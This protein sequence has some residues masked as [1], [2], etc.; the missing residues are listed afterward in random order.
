MIDSIDS[1]IQHLSDEDMPIFSDT[2]TDVTST[3]NSDDTSAAD[4]ANSILKDAS[5]TSRLLKMANSHYYNP[6]RYSITTITRAVMVLGFDQVRALALSLILIDSIENDT[7][8]EKIAEE[9]AQ[10]F[11]A[12]VQAEQLARLTK[13]KVP[14]DIFVATLLSHLGNLAFWAFSGEKGTELQL[15]ID[16]GGISEKEAELKVLGFSLQKLTQGLSKAWSLGELLDNSFNN[17]FSDDPLVKL[18]H[19]G[20]ELAQS[21]KKDWNNNEAYQVIEK[22]AEKLNIPISNVQDLVYD[23]AKQAKNITKS[24][25]ITTAS[26]LIP[27][28]NIALVELE[29]EN[30]SGGDE[31]ETI[32]DEAESQQQKIQNI[33]SDIAESCYP[34]PDPNI[35]LSVLQEITEAIADKPNINVIIEMVL[36]GIHRGV[37]MDRALFAILS[38]DRKSLVCKYALGE[39]NIVLN[40][41]FK[42]DISHRRNIF[43]QVVENK[44]G[45]H[46]PSNPN[47][48]KGTVG[49]NIFEL[50]GYPPYLIMPTI[51][52]GKVIGIFLADRNKSKRQIKDKDFLSFQQFCLQANM[53]LTFLTMQD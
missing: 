9:M 31:E 48:I 24:Y 13:V 19:L 15:L 30:R 23:N 14:E 11:H 51:V 7:N 38:N 36:E 50:L 25:G 46:I 10:S 5:L 35:Q 33:D 32:V 20:Q 41:Q 21:A 18:I 44:K 42:I 17:D 16:S 37:G 6:G 52:G 8:R 2:V 34:E 22:V 53:G 40:E 1:W 27:Q 28:A 49:K 39:G 12:A 43:R 29:D 45:V 3:V 4:V 26:K 47:D